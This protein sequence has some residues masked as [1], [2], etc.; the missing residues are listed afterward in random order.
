MSKNLVI[1]T[2]TDN[3]RQRLKAPVQ[4]LFTLT[5]SDPSFS[6]NSYPAI[7]WKILPFQQMVP[8][9]QT[10]SWGAELGFSVVKQQEDGTVT[11][12]DLCMPV[13][14]KHM[15]ILGTENGLVN[16]AETRKM[17]NAQAPVISVFNKTG[18][19]QHLALCSVDESDPEGPKFYPVVDLGNLKHN[20]TIECGPP[21]MLQAYAVS[22]Y[23]EGQV[24]KP[25]DLNRVLFVDPAG[26]PQPRDIRQ[27]TS[28]DAF[29]LYT[30][31]SGKVI[32]E[33]A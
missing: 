4:V 11:P 12:G 16:F 19:P 26:D 14:P 2:A 5:P 28:G 23:K 29:R 3:A 9:Q 18:V 31:Y 21:V 7:A 32:L 10:L 17:N 20:T 15:A 33:S 27:M 13:D 25:G 22:G 6:P 8:A 30:N 1:F 24:L